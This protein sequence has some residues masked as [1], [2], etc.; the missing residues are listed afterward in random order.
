MDAELQDQECRCE[1]YRTMDLI[2]AECHRLQEVDAPLVHRFTKGLYIREIY[3]KAGSLAVTKI[4]NTEHP[5]VISKG[6]VS[7][8][9]DCEHWDYIEAPFTGI[10][11]PGTQRFIIVYED[12]IWTTFHPNPDDEKDLEKIEAR[13]IIPHQIPKELLSDEKP[14]QIESQDEKQIEQ[15]A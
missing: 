2:E 15:E 6:K 7:V 1:G 14:I 8:S 3:L 5:Y 12:T 10:T 13:I 11:K 9:T 4:H